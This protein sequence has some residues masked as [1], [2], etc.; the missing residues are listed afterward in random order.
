MR[1]YQYR[2]EECGK[3]FERT[4]GCRAGFRVDSAAPLVARNSPIYLRL[5]TMTGCPCLAFH[6]ESAKL[7]VGGLFH[8]TC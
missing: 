3:T 7:S 2:C 8:S 6:S 4:P 1:T 5:E